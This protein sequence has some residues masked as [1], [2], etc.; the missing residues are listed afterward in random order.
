MPPA[1]RDSWRGRSRGNGQRTSTAMSSKEGSWA[2][3]SRADLEHVLAEQ[4]HPG[5]AV[6]LLQMA[7]GG[8]RRAAVEDANVVQPQ[9]AAFKEVLAEAVFAVHPPTEVQ[10]SAFEKDRLRNSRSPLP[11]RACSVLYRKIVAQACTGGLTS[12]K[13]HS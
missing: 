5:G 2:A 1:P 11:L 12:L 3:S 4:R 8:Q 6:S 9:K 10:R 13:F 7:A